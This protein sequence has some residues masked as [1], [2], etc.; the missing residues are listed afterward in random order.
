MVMRGKMCRPSGEW[1]RPWETI[2][3]AGIF[4]SDFPLNL[5]WPPTGLR[6]PERVRRVVVLPAPLVPMRVTTS[7]ASTLKEMPLT[8]W[9]LP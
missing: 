6:R 8:A 4:L 2:S 1:A 5:I 9:I 3:W 7:P